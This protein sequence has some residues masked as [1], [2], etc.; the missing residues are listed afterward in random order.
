VTAAEHLRYGTRWQRWFVS[1]RPRYPHFWPARPSG[2]IDSCLDLRNTNQG[3][4]LH[5]TPGSMPLS[6]PRKET[7]IDQSRDARPSFQTARQAPGKTGG[8]SAVCGEIQSR[9]P[10]DSS[11]V[12]MTRIAWD[13][14]PWLLFTCFAQLSP[15]RRRHHS[16]TA[17]NA[18][19]QP[20]APL[21]SAVETP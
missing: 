13:I 5:T 17:R 11:V 19:S 16:E 3:N 21:H 1:D 18:A 6:S 15:R 9:R 12:K 14:P 7:C 20:R 2:S 4:G 10:P 8:L